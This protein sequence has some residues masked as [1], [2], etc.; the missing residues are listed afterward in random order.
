MMEGKHQYKV[1]SGVDNNMSS[2]YLFK[3]LSEECIRGTNKVKKV[4]NQ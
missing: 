2:Q 4:S 1:F 3:T